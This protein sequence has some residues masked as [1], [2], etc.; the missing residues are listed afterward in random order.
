MS[1]MDSLGSTVQVLRRWRKIRICQLMELGRV[2]RFVPKSLSNL[3]GHQDFMPSTTRKESIV[4]PASFTLW[5]R[6]L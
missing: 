1:T 4:I 6:F 5:A 3:L 2:S